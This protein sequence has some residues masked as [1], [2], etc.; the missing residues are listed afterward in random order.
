MCSHFD[1]DKRNVS[2]FDPSHSHNSYVTCAEEAGED[3]YFAF[4]SLAMR[5]HGAILKELS[6]F[7]ALQE[8][9]PFIEHLGRNGHNVLGAVGPAP[10]EMD[11]R[12]NV[13][14]LSGLQNRHMASEAPRTKV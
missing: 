5:D 3:G 1:D 8:Q 9:C 12:Y 13:D 7:R 10:S 11:F 14:K 6:S 2:D 4:V